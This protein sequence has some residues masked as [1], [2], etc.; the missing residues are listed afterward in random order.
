MADYVKL[1]ATAQ[2]LIEANGRNI[3]F[4]K[5]ADVADDA[6]APWRGS[7]TVRSAGATSSGRGVVVDPVSARNLGFKSEDVGH[8]PMVNEVLIVAANTFPSVALEQMDEVN[9]EDNIYKI[10]RVFVLKP[11]DVKLLY[12]FEIKTTGRFQ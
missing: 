10:E 7:T 1:A 2:R 11:G 5:L 12:F 4:R 3:T 8:V 6:S 9:D